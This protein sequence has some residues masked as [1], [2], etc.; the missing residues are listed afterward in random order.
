[1]VWIIIA[2]IMIVA[3]GPILWLMPSP[4]E[5]RLSSLRQRAYRLGMRVELRR[6]PGRDLAPEERVTAGGRALDTTRE[7]AAY[8]KPLAARLRMLPSW[9]VLRGGEGMA[10]VPGWSFQP[11]ERPEHPRLDTM[12]EAVAGGLA[13]LPD[14]VVAV[15]VEPHG[16]AAYWLEGAGTTPERVDDLA[17]RLGALG[18]VIRELDD[19]LRS[20]AEPRN[21]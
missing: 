3:F 5:R 16:V 7:C 20:E 11:G 6:M 15:E 13:D 14:D 1:M 8:V 17:V 21:I 12:L 10:A 18:D 9:R 4:R 2:L 19:R